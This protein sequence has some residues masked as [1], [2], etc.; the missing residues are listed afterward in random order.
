VGPAVATTEFEEDVDGKPPGGCIWWVRQWPPPRLKKTMMVSP[1]GA[2]PAGP[3]VTTTE[4]ED[5]ID[6]RP[7]RGLVVGRGWA[8]GGALPVGL[9]A[10]TTEVEDDVEGGALGEHYWRVRQ[11]PPPSLKKTSMMAPLRGTA[12]G[13]D[14][15]HH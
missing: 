15:V 9:A 14:S 6:G 12:S 1:M 4:G 7:Q 5:D 13:S 8:P 11:C 2:L 10:A 3:T